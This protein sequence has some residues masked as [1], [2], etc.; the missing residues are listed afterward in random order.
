MPLRGEPEQRDRQRRDQADLHRRAAAARPGQRQGRAGQH[1]QADPGRAVQAA[2]HGLGDVRD[3]GLGQPAELPVHLVPAEGDQREQRQHRAERGEREADQHAARPP[4]PPA[5]GRDQGVRD[6]QDQRDDVEQPGTGQRE[7]VRRPAQGG[8]PVQGAQQQQGGQRG[9]EDHEGVAAD[10]LPVPGH[11]GDQ[12]E[13]GARDQSGGG[14]EELA[15]DQGDEGGG[16]GHRQR[17]GRPER[18][19]R[20]PG[21]LGPEVDQ[22]V[23]GADHGVQVVQQVEDLVRRAARRVPGGQLVVPE[24]R[25]AGPVQAGHQGQ[26]GGPHPQQAA[27]P[28]RC[29]PPGAPPGVPPGGPRRGLRGLDGVRAGRGAGDR[30]DA[31]AARPGRCP[32]GRAGE[33]AGRGRRTRGRHE[34]R[35]GTGSIQ[36]HRHLP[37]HGGTTAPAGGPAAGAGR[38]GGVRPG[39]AP[40]PSGSVRAGWR[41]GACAAP[42]RR[43]SP[44]S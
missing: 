10:L 33:V 40:W 38:P 16:T 11:R 23:V 9:E 3:G 1:Q 4:G 29:A 6:D 35:V 2:P 37:G 7:R 31:H 17:G 44:P 32:A 28:G 15:A 42:R 21:Q 18:D 5:S 14:R 30:S 27:G 22:E 20:V 41:A 39:G 24:Q 8:R 19:D 12:R 26:R 13:Q 34:R 36:T 43:G 25:A